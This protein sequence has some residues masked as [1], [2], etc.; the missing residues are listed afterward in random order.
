MILFVGDDQFL[1]NWYLKNLKESDYL[2]EGVPLKDLEEA[3]SR[4]P[5]DLVLIDLPHEAESQNYISQ[6]LRVRPATP[7]VLSV[8]MD[9]F[10]FA[11]EAFRSGAAEILPKPMEP[12]LML[13]ILHR[14]LEEDR[15]LKENKELRDYVNL[16]SACQRITTQIEGEG[17]R[18]AT[19]DAL[20]AKTGIRAAFYLDWSSVTTVPQTEGL[21][22]LNESEA[23]LFLD[24]LIPLIRLRFNV[25]EAYKIVFDTQDGE[26]RCLRE[27]GFTEALIVPLHDHVSLLGLFILLRREQDPLWTA[28][29]VEEVNFIR[30]HATLAWYNAALYANAKELAMLDDLTGLYNVRYLHLAIGRE[31]IHYRESSVPFAVLFLDIDYLKRVNDFHGHQVGSQLL[32]EVA[33]VLRRCVRDNDAVVRY[34]GDEF[35]I[36]LKATPLSSAEQIADR[37]RTM[38]SQHIFLGR[39][40]LKVQ[41][42]VCIGV[43]S[44][45]V[46]AQSEEELIFLSDRAMY[47][48]KNSTR[49]LV[50]TADPEDLVRSK[51]T[52][53]C[54]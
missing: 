2:T 14:V 44:C 31:L 24:E 47:R 16:Y 46:H 6:A 23:R 48:G 36:V 41:I 45:P 1:R 51:K 22:G 32:R 50:I 39:E 11:G 17:V 29:V 25:A 37:I 52:E 34:G 18:K 35:V 43:A 53:P 19:L 42:T 7:V 13:M 40:G 26:F 27:N 54:N 9:R 38:M 28:K 33:Q 10:N 21:L 5:A 20:V 8:E 3:L 15:L 12:R 30:Q 49:N 4:F